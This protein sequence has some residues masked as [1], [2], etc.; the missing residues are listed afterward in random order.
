MEIFIAYSLIF[1][2]IV[3]FVGYQFCWVI[4]IYYYHRGL[5]T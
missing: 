2:G 3:D 1:V 4:L 5:R